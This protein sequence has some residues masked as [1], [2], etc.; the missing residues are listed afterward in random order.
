MRKQ[1]ILVAAAVALLLGPQPTKLRASP[2][3]QGLGYL[4]G[5]TQTNGYFY[6]IN[7]AD[8]YSELIGEP[9]RDLTG[10]AYILEPAVIPAPSAILLGTIGVGF[11]TWLRRRR[12][13]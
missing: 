8:G 1:S 10:L 9:V 11:V 4:Y 2:S 3:R 13:L 6:R 5:I 12:T 7:P